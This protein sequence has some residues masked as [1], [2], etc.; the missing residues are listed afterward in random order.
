MLNIK[1]CK[2]NTDIVQ[3]WEREYVNLNFV[4]T[5]SSGIK[6]QECLMQTKNIFTQE[7]HSHKTSIKTFF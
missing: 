4:H 5:S 1:L 3:T 2:E 7:Y 6:R